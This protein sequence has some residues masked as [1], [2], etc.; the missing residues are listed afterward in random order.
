MKII[1]MGIGIMLFSILLQLCSSGMEL[2]SLIIGAAGLA[3][4]IRG[5]IG[6]SN[7]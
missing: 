2:V 3:F 4:V 1:G 5:A 6:K 7:S